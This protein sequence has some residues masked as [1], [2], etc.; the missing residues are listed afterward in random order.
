MSALIKFAYPLNGLVK[1]AAVHEI[2]L[3]NSRAQQYNLCLSEADALQIVESRDAWLRR[4]GRIEL[5]SAVMRNIILAFC[6]SPY[7][8]Q[9]DYTTTISELIAIFYYAKNET[10]EE[11][12]DEDLIYFLKD[13]FNNRCFGVIELLAGRE[14]EQLIHQVRFRQTENLFH[15][16]EE[17]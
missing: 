11:I 10:N 2:T 16:A 4:L 8:N 9:A 17:E 7:I 15:R 1:Q 12:S 13:G 3:T 5:S 6:D 14:L